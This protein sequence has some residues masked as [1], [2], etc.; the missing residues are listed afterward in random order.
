[1]RGASFIQLNPPCT[2]ML[3]AHGLFVPTAEQTAV[4][5]SPCSAL[6]ELQALDIVH[7][8]I[9]PPNMLLET[10]NPAA[11]INDNA[12]G[13]KGSDAG[14]STLARLKLID[15]GEANKQWLADSVEVGTP[16]YMAPEV[17]QLGDCSSA[18]DVYS[19]GVSL[20]ELW[21]G[22]LWAGAETRGEGSAGMRRELVE[23][24]ELPMCAPIDN[25]RRPAHGASLRVSFGEACLC[26][27]LQS[28]LPRIH[29]L[30][31]CSL[32]RHCTR[33]RVLNRTWRASCDG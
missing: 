18:S 5:I 11:P 16:G 8:D 4:C 24:S 31:A 15:F 13:V 32:T 21:S 26:G 27:P 25:S 19:A 1:M 6:R 3:I 28:M 9:K 10:V 17:A 23:V 30:S 20:L 33:L 29:C 12:A 7:C 14:Q 2:R 22:G